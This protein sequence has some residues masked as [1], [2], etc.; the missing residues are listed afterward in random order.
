MYRMG[1]KSLIIIAITLSTANQLSWFFFDFH[2]NLLLCCPTNST[3]IR[4]YLLFWPW[5]HL[6][7]TL[8]PPR[9]LRRSA[10]PRHS[11]LRRSTCLGPRAK[12]MPPRFLYAGYGP[13][14][15]Y[16]QLV[17]AVTVAACNRWH[18]H[19]FHSEKFSSRHADPR[20][21]V[22]VVELVQTKSWSK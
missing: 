4:P 12:L 19:H 2:N 8:H 1:Q 6:L 7:R 13:V 21:T 11:R 9:R 20:T 17:V 22:V 3:F 18:C 16:S 15:C 10:A 14:P 5:G